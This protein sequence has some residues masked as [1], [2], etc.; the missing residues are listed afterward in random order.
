MA[1]FAGR[2]PASLEAGV[3]E[4]SAA[5]GSRARS[6]ASEAE[7]GLVEVVPQSRTLRELS[8]GVAHEDRHLR[9]SRALQ[10]DPA[11][12]DRLASSTVAYLTAGYALGHT[13]SQVRA[14]SGS[15]WTKYQGGAGPKRSNASPMTGRSIGPR[16]T[17]DRP[18]TETTSTP[19][20]G[21]F[22]PPN[23]P[24]I[25]PS[26]A[27][28]R[29]QID[30]RS[31]RIDPKS[32]SWAVLDLFI[33]ASARLRRSGALFEQLSAEAQNLEIGGRT[34]VSHRSEHRPAAMDLSTSSWSDLGQLLPKPVQ[35]RP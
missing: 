7:G 17:P 3:V 2:A 27:P 28:S 11:R 25:G 13:G 34:L 15:G 30:P 35:A 20:R 10:N 22:S 5:A 23:R 6:D 21:R 32:K 33:L 16:S 24:R 9:V 12:L 26:S 1:A 31:I 18:Q 14:R 29:P 4:C 8:S 19:M